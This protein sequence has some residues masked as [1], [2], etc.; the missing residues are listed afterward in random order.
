DY[1][2]Q[3]AARFGVRFLRGQR[4]TLRFGNSVVNL[5]G[6]DYQPWSERRN[7]L[8][9][10]EKLVTPGAINVLLSHNPDVF[11]AAAHQGYNLVLAGHTHGGQISVEILDQYINPARFFTPF[12]YGTYRS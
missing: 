4:E 8:A 1:T 9:G 3:A 12:I 5:A 10:K 6:I 11:P 2:A 7:Y